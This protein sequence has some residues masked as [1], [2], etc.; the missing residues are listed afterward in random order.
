M[1]LRLRVCRRS[2][3]SLRPLH[4]R[5]WRRR[6]PLRRRRHVSRRQA[7]AHVHLQAGT[8]R[9]PV[10][11]VHLGDVH[12]QLRVSSREGVHQQAV[13]EPL[14]HSQPVSSLRQ[15]RG[16]GS[17]TGLLVSAR[18]LGRSGLGMRHRRR[19]MHLGRKVS[20]ATGLSVRKVRPALSSG[21]AVRK[22][23]RVLGARHPASQDHDVR[24]YSRVR[25][26][27]FKGVHAR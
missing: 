19:G 2:R 9:K 22:V 14:R 5:L 15:L 23:R 25:G 13:P 27:R 18:N 17:R 10:R 21:R 4:A 20:V 11:V 1:S 26:R 24:V 16:V 3:L 7:S 12:G 6:P 8:D